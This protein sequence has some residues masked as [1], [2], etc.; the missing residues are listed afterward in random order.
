MNLTHDK[1]L[2]NFALNLHCLRPYIPA[3]GAGGNYAV[4]VV[5]LRAQRVAARLHGHT[6]HITAGCCSLNPFESA[7]VQLL[8]MT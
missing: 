8:K 3:C 6:C 7:W 2:S 5:D 4:N 1:P